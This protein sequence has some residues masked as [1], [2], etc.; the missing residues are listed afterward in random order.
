MRRQV[1]HHQLNVQKAPGNRIQ[2]NTFHDT[3][4]LHSAEL[5]VERTVRCLDNAA[6]VAQKGNAV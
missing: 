5:Y 4:N 3:V 6:A 2:E 1:I